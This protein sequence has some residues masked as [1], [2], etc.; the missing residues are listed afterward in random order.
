MVRFGGRGTRRSPPGM[1]I[2][3]SISAQWGQYHSLRS[4]T[5]AIFAMPLKDSGS[6]WSD[7]MGR[8]ACIGS[9]STAS[10]VSMDVA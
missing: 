7:C 4:L 9:G 1:S 10:F 3:P 5:S 6:P 2:S 8:S